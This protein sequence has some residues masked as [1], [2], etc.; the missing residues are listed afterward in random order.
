MISVSLLVVVKD[1]I[2]A[3]IP[4]FVS[5]SIDSLEAGLQHWLCQRN[6]PRRSTMHSAW[7]YHAREEA[8]FPR[9]S[10]ETQVSERLVWKGHKLAVSCW[11]EFNRCKNKIQ[12]LF[13]RKIHMKR[14][15]KANRV[16]EK[17]R[18]EKFKCEPFLNC[19]CLSK[20]WGLKT[21]NCILVVCGWSLWKESVI[22]LI[23]IA[24]YLQTGEMDNCCRMYHIP[25]WCFSFLLLF[26]DISTL[27]PC[28]LLIDKDSK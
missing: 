28:G 27:F 23:R 5:V 1:Q 10:E 19:S 25:G 17:A 6:S 11:L 26:I 12:D 9:S 2:S 4:V 24:L 13:K 8:I 20:G 18:I 7:Y 14:N 16:K 15:I 3:A 21:K 22:E